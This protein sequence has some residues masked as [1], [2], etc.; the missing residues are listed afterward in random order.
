MTFFWV[1]V[2]SIRSRRLH[3]SAS[4]HTLVLL[5]ILACFFPSDAR[6]VRLFPSRSHNIHLPRLLYYAIDLDPNR[7]IC[8]SHSLVELNTDYLQALS[9]YQSSH[10]KLLAICATFTSILLVWLSWSPL[11]RTSPSPMN[12]IFDRTPLSHGDNTSHQRK[13]TW[14]LSLWLLRFWLS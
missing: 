7:Q 14:R 13:L 8:I 4:L 3:C 5:R 10:T 6:L 9:S 1:V 12:P 2:A 11:R